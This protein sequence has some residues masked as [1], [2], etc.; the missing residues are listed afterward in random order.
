MFQ[1]G[2]SS[3]SPSEVVMGPPLDM[4]EPVRFEIKVGGSDNW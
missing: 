3:N 1:V 4:T 2:E